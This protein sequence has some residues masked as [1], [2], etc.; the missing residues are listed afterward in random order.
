LSH[1]GDRTP[2]RDFNAKGYQS[3][4]DWI[5]RP[6]RWTS[7]HFHLTDESHSEG[8]K[9]VGIELQI[10]DNIEE[11]FWLTFLDACVD[12]PSTAK[13][14]YRCLGDWSSFKSQGLTRER[15]ECAE[16][17]LRKGLVGNHRDQAFAKKGAKGAK[18]IDRFVEIVQKYVSLVGS[19][20]RRWLLGSWKEV[21][22]DKQSDFFDD[23]MTFLTRGVSKIDTFGR[24]T[25]FDYLERVGRLGLLGID[26][27]PGRMYLEDSSSPLS[28]LSIVLTGSCLTR[29]RIRDWMRQTKIPFSQLDQ[30]GME[31]QA[32]L[33][34]DPRIA[35]VGLVS[36]RPR[37]LVA[38]LADP[39]N[40]ETALCC[41]CESTRNKN[42]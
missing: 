3:F 4:V 2:S 22:P 36:K 35:N 38:I 5:I 15:V 42:H 10:E 9:K 27:L 29:A 31:L 28:G 26:F 1:D 30:I 34:R 33:L 24:T 14:L 16:K 21:S 6:E 39:R 7:A 8:L 40:F 17:F 23:R 32:K 20:Q 19:A 25:A 41:F 37:T 18:W 11:M 12:E 13:K